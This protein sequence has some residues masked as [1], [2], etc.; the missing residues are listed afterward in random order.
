MPLIEEK[1]LQSS[2]RMAPKMGVEVKKQM[3]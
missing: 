2:W 3:T 1:T